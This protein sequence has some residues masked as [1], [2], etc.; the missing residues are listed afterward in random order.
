M[1]RRP[2]APAPAAPPEPIQL[3]SG[4]ASARANGEPPLPALPADRKEPAAP[5]PTPP[6][7]R[8]RPSPRLPTPSRPRSPPRDAGACPGAD[9]TGCGG[10]AA[11]FERGRRADRGPRAPARPGPSG[12]G[13]AES[14]RRAARGA[15][16]RTLDAHRG[17]G[18]RDRVAPALARHGRPRPGRAPSG[19]ERGL[20]PRPGPRAGPRRGRSAAVARGNLHASGP[21]ARCGGLAAVARDRDPAR[22]SGPE[23]A[24]AAPRPRTRSPPCPSSLRPCPHPRL[25]AGRPRARISRILPR[26]C[27]P[28]CNARSIGSRNSRMRRT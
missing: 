28:S 2:T 15:G 3:T 20:V 6:A 4:A 14:P 25:R 11:A 21:G 26:R 9:R 22:A 7:H 10:I 27:L 8:H 18:P 5:A 1:S 13:A 24:R 23:P 19:P 17:P 16:P 12:R